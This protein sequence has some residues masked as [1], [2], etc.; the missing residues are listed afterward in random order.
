MTAVNIPEEFGALIVHLQK[1]NMMCEYKHQ[2][3]RQNVKRCNSAFFM[4]L[5]ETREIR[6]SVVLWLYILFMSVLFVLLSTLLSSFTVYCCTP[7]KAWSFHMYN[8]VWLL[9]YH[10][11][12]KLLQTNLGNHYHTSLASTKDKYQTG[13]WAMHQAAGQT[14]HCALQ[15]Y[16]SGWWQPDDSLV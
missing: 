3:N 11:L 5:I 8:A 14:I 7:G 15:I 9:Q 1:A 12:V 13:V 2:Q 16:I 4:L 6:L 10:L